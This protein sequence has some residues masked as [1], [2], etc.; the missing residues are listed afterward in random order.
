M[1]MAV[2]NWCVCT[3]SGAVSVPGGIVDAD[4]CAERGNLRAISG[5][6]QNGLCHRWR[7]NQHS[8]ATVRRAEHMGQGNA[9]RNAR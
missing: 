2:I 3:R 1:D 6:G 7:G 8:A 5:P 4:N 9:C